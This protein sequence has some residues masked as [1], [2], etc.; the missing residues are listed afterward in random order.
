MIIWKVSMDRNFVIEHDFTDY[1]KIFLEEN[2]KLNLISK[3]DE[4]FLYEKHIYDSLSIKLTNK[5]SDGKT[6][7]DIGCGGGFPCVPIAIEFPEVKVV[8]IDSIRKKINAVNEIKEKLCISN[9]SLICD[10]V[11]NIKGQ[12]F[13]I[14]TSRAVADLSVIAEY[15]LPLLKKDGVFVAYKSKKTTEELE[16]AKKILAS[17]KA[18]VLDIIE[19]SLPLNEKYERTLI[20][21]GF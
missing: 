5:I 6:L 3:N 19:Y 13:D 4:K 11:E 9:L 12:R 10:R 17:Y 18:R 21:I 7:L 2:T 8:G 15:A 16:N 20:V 1:K 14:I